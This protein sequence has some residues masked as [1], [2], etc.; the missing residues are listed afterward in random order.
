MPQDNGQRSETRWAMLSS[1]NG[2]ALRVSGA[3]PF[4]FTARR[5]TSEQL[6]TAMHPT[7]LIAGDRVWL[8]LDAYQ[9]GL[10]S[11]SCGAGVHPKY[12]HLPEETTMR[13]RF[14]LI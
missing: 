5:W 2:P 11:A 13:L 7:E 3:D 6:E 9:Y 10:G 12:R 1:E 8:T 14:E 4:G